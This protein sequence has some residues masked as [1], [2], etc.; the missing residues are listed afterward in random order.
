MFFLP[1][2]GIIVLP[3]SP[4]AMGKN[5]PWVRVNVKG[6]WSMVMGRGQEGMVNGLGRSMGKLDAQSL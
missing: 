6:W 4:K 5:G 3:S 2:E 1:F